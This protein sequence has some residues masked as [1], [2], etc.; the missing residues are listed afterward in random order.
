M[1]ATTCSSWT[2]TSCACCVEGSR[3]GSTVQCG[4][5]WS[6]DVR[7]SFW[8]IRRSVCHHLGCKKGLHKVSSTS[9]SPGV[10][11][12]LSW[13]VGARQEGQSQLL[14]ITD[15]YVLLTIRV[16]KYRNVSSF[17]SP[18]SYTGGP[19]IRTTTDNMWLT[20]TL[21]FLR[22]IPCLRGSSRTSLPDSLPDRVSFF[23]ISP[24]SCPVE[25]LF[26]VGGQVDDDRRVSL[27]PDKMTLL[28][29]M[30]ETL[31]L[32]RKIRSDRIVHTVRHFN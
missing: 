26:S 32:V 2:R 16:V 10:F 22:I 29:F 3:P 13:C 6:S 30:D 19:W 17:H 21:S 7:T 24:T 11:R 5:C 31:S 18:C 27:S 28:V 23:V 20:P 4:M 14:T 8:R 9:E 12:S 15:Y 1:W 25:R